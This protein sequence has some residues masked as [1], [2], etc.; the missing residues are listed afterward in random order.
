M[1]PTP[2]HCLSL[3]QQPTNG[4]RHPRPVR[5]EPASSAQGQAQGLITAGAA[6]P[7]SSLWGFTR[8][9]VT[10]LFGPS[11]IFIGD[12]AI[13]ARSRCALGGHDWQT[14]TTR[15]Q[16]GSLF[17]FPSPGLKLDNSLNQTPSIFFVP[18]NEDHPFTSLSKPI[19]RSTSR[20]AR[21]SL[22]HRFTSHRTLAT[23][24]NP[25]LFWSIASISTRSP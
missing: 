16:D 14:I 15:H 23:S 4:R 10:S 25:Y 17:F 1:R 7:P 2:P 20:G 8:P 5:K 21:H 3:P 18:F 9:V 22:Q 11:P 12:K 6:P 19:A 13:H 24:T